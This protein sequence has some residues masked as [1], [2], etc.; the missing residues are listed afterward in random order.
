MF[1]HTTLN[2]LHQL[3]QYT[4]H[5]LHTV[6]FHIVISALNSFILLYFVSQYSSVVA[7][8]SVLVQL[9]HTMIHYTTHYTTDYTTHYTTHYYTLYHTL[10]CTLQYIL[11]DMLC[12]IH[13]YTVYYTL[14]YA[15]CYS[16][17]F[18]QFSLLSCSIPE[19]R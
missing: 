12:T 17:Y 19:S 14:Y 4:V 6:L 16:L 5:C 11:C 2:I 10:Q 8:A 18:L 15:P 13:Y 9:Q 3:K 7:S 1:L